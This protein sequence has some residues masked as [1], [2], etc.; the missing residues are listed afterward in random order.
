MRLRG[1]NV[2]RQIDW[3]LALVGKQEVK[4][5]ERLSLVF[6]IFQE[7]QGI[8]QRQQKV[9]TRKKLLRLTNTKESILSS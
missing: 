7:E 4:I 5:L 6:N 1:E 9:T 2:V 3:H 8:N